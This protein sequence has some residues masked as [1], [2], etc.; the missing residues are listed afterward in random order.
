MSTLEMC[1]ACD[2]PARVCAIEGHRG[3]VH[4]FWC[5]RRV[6]GG[7]GDTERRTSRELELRLGAAQKLIDGVAERHVRVSFPD[8]APLTD[9]DKRIIASHVAQDAA[10]SL[11]EYVCRLGDVERRAAILESELGMRLG[12]MELGS[13]LEQN[14]LDHFKSAP[15]RDELLRT[16]L[17]LRKVQDEFAAFR[18]RDLRRPALMA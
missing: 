2:R 6:G 15:L 4:V 1:F 14:D 10:R 17:E 9:G 7:H 12:P 13:L 3:D 5:L 11:F 8:Y 18:R 16:Q